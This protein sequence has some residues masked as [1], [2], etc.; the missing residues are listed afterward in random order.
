MLGAQYGQS[1][2][3]LDRLI[4]ALIKKDREGAWDKSYGVK[5]EPSPYPPDDNYDLDPSSIFPSF[6]EI[7]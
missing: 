5:E 1:T 3:F 4:P 6:P 2:F 7:P